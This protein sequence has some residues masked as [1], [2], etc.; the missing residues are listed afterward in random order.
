[1]PDEIN[2]EGDPSVRHDPA[3]PE[4]GSAPSP[5]AASGDA[6]LPDEQTTGSIEPSQG[7][8]AAAGVPVEAS[9][10]LIRKKKKKK[11]KKKDGGGLGTSR[12]IET[13]FRTSYRVNM[14]LSALADTKSNIMISINGIIISIILASISP[15]IDTNAWLLFPTT[16][17]LL[18]CLLSMVYA[19]LAARPRVNSSLITLEDVRRNRANILFFGNFVSLTRDDYIQGMTELLQDTDRLY[20]NMIVD[21]YGLG[22]VLQKKFRLLRFSYTIFMIALVMGVLI[23]IFVYIMVATGGIDTAQG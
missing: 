11:K 8:A 4:G 16:V 9:D 19:V 18:G 13:M 3:G 15:K 1:M 12:G 17:L 22:S 20:H 7:A 5:A 14:D 2:P 6:T 23:F 21:I 10:V